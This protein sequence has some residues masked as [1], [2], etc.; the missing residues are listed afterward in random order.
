MKIGSIRLSPL[1]LKGRAYLENAKVR[2]APLCLRTR[3][4]LNCNLVEGIIMPQRCLALCI[5]RGG[6]SAASG[7]RFLN[8]LR[9]KGSKRYFFE[10]DEFP[11]PDDVASAAFLAVEELKCKGSM[12][13][14]GIPGQ[15]VVVRRVELPSTVKENIR[16]V[17][18][19][20]IDRLTPLD[21]AD[22]M[23]DFIAGAQ[24]D[25]KLSIT[26]MAARK[27]TVGPYVKALTE[28]RFPPELISTPAGIMA[29]DV[30]PE[31]PG[32]PIGN[33]DIRSFFKTKEEDV[34]FAPAAML[35]AALKPGAKSIDLAGDN[36][37]GKDKAPFIT[38]LILAVLLVA[39]V[40][41]YVV[42]PLE[43]E[44]RKISAIEGQIKVRRK[45]VTDV[46]RLKKEM[47]TLQ[48]EID[49][50]DDFKKTKPMSLDVLKGLTLLLPKTAWVTRTRVTEE[51]VEIEGYAASATGV[52]SLL[53]QSSLFQQVEFASPTVKDARLNAER[54]VIRMKPEGFKKQENE[55]E[56]TAKKD[57]AKK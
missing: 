9:L 14:L 46:E 39:M 31:T 23:Y 53:E 42:V 18:A 37:G 47:E 36:A 21:A 16:S 52:L 15:W 7:E 51:T 2:L 12:V 27:A 17:M 8:R 56:G 4:A 41:P 24:A 57:E 1:F 48:G 30:L 32:R 5:E 20:E 50:I 3:A 6:M 28:R 25:G 34:P 43:M 13:L 19:Y 40:I 29:G 38:T 44:K 10:K 35:Y 49:R 54:F 33:G 55:K 22:A 11:A 26:L 45:D